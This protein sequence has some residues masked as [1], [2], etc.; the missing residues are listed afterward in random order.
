MTTSNSCPLTTVG[1]KDLGS[2]LNEIL[3]SLHLSWIKLNSSIYVN[4]N[5]PMTIGLPIPAE[6]TISRVTSN[7][8]DYLFLQP[9]LGYKC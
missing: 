6:N 1:S 4:E 9:G 8:I 2:A 5:A 7:A 3:S